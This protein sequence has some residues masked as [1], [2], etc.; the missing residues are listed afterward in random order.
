MPAAVAVQRDPAAK[1]FYERLVSRGKKP[2]Q[3]YVAVMRK[4]L[5]GIL[6][7]REHQALYDSNLLFPSPKAA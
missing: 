5:H 3:A 7:M 4:F 1:A 6:A 2:M